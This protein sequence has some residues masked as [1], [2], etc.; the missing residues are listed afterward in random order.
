MQDAAKRLDLALWAQ[1]FDRYALAVDMVGQM[2]FVD[3]IAHKNIVLEVSNLATSEGRTRLLGVLY[4]ELA[5]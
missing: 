1:A 3:A 2:C 5:R 4:D